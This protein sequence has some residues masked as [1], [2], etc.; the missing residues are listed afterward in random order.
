MN[1][2]WKKAFA[3]R[4][5]INE[6]GRV[7][8]VSLY[9]QFHSCTSMPYMNEWTCRQNDRDSLQIFFFSFKNFQKVMGYR[10]PRGVLAA[11]L[12]NSS[13]RLYMFPPIHILS[14]QLEL[15]FSPHS[16]CF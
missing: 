10:E 12:S 2:L 7:L 16:A 11:K 1:I 15:F 4:E 8:V 6:N 3:S 14:S 5:M 9:C 13:S